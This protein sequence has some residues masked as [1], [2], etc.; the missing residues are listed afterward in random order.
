MKYISAIRYHS[1]DLYIAE[2][3]I[4]DNLDAYS[5]ATAGGIIELKNGTAVSETSSAD[6]GQGSDQ[7]APVTAPA[8]QPMGAGSLPE[9]VTAHPPTP[10]RPETTAREN[11]FL[12]KR[13]F[14]SCTAETDR[15]P[16]CF[17]ALMSRCRLFPF[18][19]ERGL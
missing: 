13:R 6:S 4:P 11:M 9:A 1:Y 15:W 10:I 5:L 3:K 14:T 12:L 16:R 18:A 8:A 17:P 19:T 7:G 2:I